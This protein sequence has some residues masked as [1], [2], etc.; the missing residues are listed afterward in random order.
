[1]LFIDFR[2]VVIIRKIR[3]WDGFRFLL[4]GMLREGGKFKR[5]LNYT[6][7]IVR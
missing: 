3:K 1:M 5:F 2:L 6:G 4:L 7:K